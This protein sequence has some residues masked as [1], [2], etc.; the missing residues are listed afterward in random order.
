MEEDLKILEEM[1]FW[2]GCE[3]TIDEKWCKALENLLT[4]YKQLEE[5]ND[6]FRNGE[7]VTGKLEAKVRKNIF[8]D[9]KD[10]IHKSKIQEKIEELIKEADYKSEDN[11]NG[12]VH[13]RLEPCDYQ[14]QVLQE[15]LEEE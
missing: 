15:L 8:R 5:E 14:I 13:F 7:I 1:K 11:P 6:K 3:I 4:R 9:L 10:Y 2:E 12:R